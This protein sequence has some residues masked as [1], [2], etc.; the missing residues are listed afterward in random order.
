M[1]AGLVHLVRSILLPIQCMYS[2][3]A[4]S[5]QNLSLTNLAPQRL[6]SKLS[7]KHMVG[8]VCGLRMLKRFGRI[9]EDGW[10]QATM[11]VF[12]S[13]TGCENGLPRHLI[14]FESCSI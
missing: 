12:K 2:F 7:L 14:V 3:T 9:L 11:R 10:D 8:D 6:H 1:V 4:L 5:A 13:S